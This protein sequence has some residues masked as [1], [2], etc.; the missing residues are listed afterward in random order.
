MSRSAGQRRVYVVRHP[1]GTRLVR[2]GS[3][4]Q[5]LR[6]ACQDYRAEV[7]SQEDLIALLPAGVLVE[8]ELNSDAAADRDT[9]TQDLFEAPATAKQQEEPDAAPAPAPDLRDQVI[10]LGTRL[11]TER[12]RL[13]P[14][15]LPLELLTLCGAENPRPGDVLPWQLGE[16][17][18]DFW[19]AYYAASETH[20]HAD[21]EAQ[22]RTGHPPIKYR[23]PATG[24][25][26]TGRGL[27]PAWLVHALNS[28]GSLNDFLVSKAN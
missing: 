12:P 2:A 17:A 22:L 16:L 13:P 24:S 1:S 6:H 14:D 28:G 18:R 25:T 15:H 23:D 3:A 7:A 8:D 4:A 19:D 5:A 11:G 27:K 20:R 9:A 10:A 26:W 21:A